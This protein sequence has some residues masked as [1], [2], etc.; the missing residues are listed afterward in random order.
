MEPGL[1]LNWQHYELTNSQTEDAGAAAPA[2]NVLA[3]GNESKS[4]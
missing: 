2:H 1:R 4:G 3:A